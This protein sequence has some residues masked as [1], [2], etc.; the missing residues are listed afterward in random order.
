MHG[1][2]QWA[3]VSESETSGGGVHGRGQWASVSVSGI[4]DGDG[5][6]MPLC[7]DP[8]QEVA[9]CCD[10]HYVAIVTPGRQNAGL[11]HADRRTGNHICTRRGHSRHTFGVGPATLHVFSSQSPGTRQVLRQVLRQAALL[12]HATLAA[13]WSAA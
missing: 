2:G 12:E 7:C 4:S 3:S 11:N 13:A 1:G 6:E 5:R 10:P 9:I 8:V